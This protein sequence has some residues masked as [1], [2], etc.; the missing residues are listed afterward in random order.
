MYRKTLVIKRNGKVIR[1]N[2]YTGRRTK[3]G[4]KLQ[5]KING[6]KFSR[7]IK[8]TLRLK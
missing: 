5:G 7:F 4:I 6:K 8:N 1:S 2:N 3:K